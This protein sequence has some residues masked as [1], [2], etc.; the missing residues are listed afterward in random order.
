MNYRRLGGGVGVIKMTHCESHI[1]WTQKNILHTLL[2]IWKSLDFKA[3]YSS[4]NNRTNFILCRCLNIQKYQSNDGTHLQNATFAQCLSALCR[5]VFIFGFNLSWSFDGILF[6]FCWFGSGPLGFCYCC[7]VV[8]KLFFLLIL[9]TMKKEKEKKKAK[10]SKL[11]NLLCFLG[12]VLILKIPIRAE[13][14][15]VTWR[16]S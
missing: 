8:F 13:G 11:Q 7:Y 10:S 4:R 12:F 3:F 16:Y 5:R 15:C 2:Y 6:V 1:W 14:L 9:P